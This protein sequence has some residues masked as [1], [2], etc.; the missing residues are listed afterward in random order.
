MS[1][2]GTNGHLCMGHEQVCLN[3]SKVQG[4]RTP[5]KHWML[6]TLQLCKSLVEA[7]WRCSKIR[8]TSEQGVRRP[9]ANVLLQIV[10]LQ[11]WLATSAPNSNAAAVLTELLTPA[12]RASSGKD[13]HTEALHHPCAVL[14][15]TALQ[16]G[17]R[18]QSGDAC[19][20]KSD[21]IR[22]FILFIYVSR[23][24]CGYCQS[25]CWAAT[26]GKSAT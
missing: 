18:H 11:R 10:P 14:C 6:P 24:V 4:C 16:S 1:F 19:C 2:W 26:P 13:V 20:M 5:A 15:K 22:Y 17:S 9:A 7:A 25:V 8:L 12:V 3:Y 23:Q 21:A